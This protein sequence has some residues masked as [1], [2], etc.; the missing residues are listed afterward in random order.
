MIRPFFVEDF[1]Q[2]LLL[3]DL[4]ND[5][6]R[7]E[8]VTTE[9]WARLLDPSSAVNGLGFYEQD[10]MVGF[11]HYITHPVTG[12]I[13]PACYMQDLFVHPDQRRKGI[14]KKLVKA[15][16]KQAKQEKWAR[17]YWL[18]QDSNKAAHALYQNLGVKL[19]FSFFVMPL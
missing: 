11:V 16:T 15:L 1:S 6:Q 14:G 9:T 17:L 18:A 19:G 4:N 12:H 10:K 13:A 3:W 5:G 7:K 2:W 8:A